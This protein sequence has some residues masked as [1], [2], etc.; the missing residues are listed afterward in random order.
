MLALP[1]GPRED[2]ELRV[3]LARRTA[4]G[5]YEIS[6]SELVL[7]IRAC[8]LAGEI[9]SRDFLCEVLLERCAP[10]FQR[11]SWGLNQ[12]PD[13]REEAIAGMREHVLREA[14]NPKER[15]IVQNFIHYLRCACVDEFHRVLRDEGLFYRHD[16]EG[17]PLGR[18]TRVP[19]VLMDPLQP[20]PSED[21]GSCDVPDQE[22]Q[23]ER[24]HAREEVQ[25]LLAT[26]ADPKNRCIVALRA[27]E[28][29]HWDEIAAYMHMNE[30][31]VR[32]RY[33]KAQA[34]LRAQVADTSPG[35]ACPQAHSA[36]V[37]TLA[38]APCA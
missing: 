26:L 9:A 27:L 31:S 10:E 13:L 8:Q 19:R 32:L 11:H 37:D 33:A 16:E 7:A 15:F 30:R 20:I 6:E 34:F 25:R 4:Q 28:G 5:R 29:F 17:R 1:G 23:Y 18:P 24:L 22:D 38:S 14:L 21:E 3:R 35:T 12:R 2:A 36:Q